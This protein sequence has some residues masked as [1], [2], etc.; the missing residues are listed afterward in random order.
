MKPWVD[1]PRLLAVCSVL[2]LLAA[3]SPQSGSTT[4]PSD[5]ASQGA[6]DGTSADDD[7]SGGDAEEEEFKPDNPCTLIP[8]D[9]L[10][11]ALGG[12][13]VPDREPQIGGSE[14][15]CFIYGPTDPPAILT[16][17]MSSSGP[18]GY[19]IQKGYVV[20][21]GLEA[22]DLPGIGDAA[23]AFGPGVTMLVGNK[24]VYLYLEGLPF[25]NVPEADRLELVKNLAIAA[26]AELG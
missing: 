12:P 9:A 4:D 10:A 14:V 1:L 8:D 17:R 3:C 21:S 5:E 11:I 7:S 13:P 2:V 26:A 15:A 20:D 25:D 18:Q 23:F 16:V 19:E 24:V 22:V 6:D